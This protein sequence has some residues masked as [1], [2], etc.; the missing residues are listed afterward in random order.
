MTTVFADEYGY[1]AQDGGSALQAAID[2]PNADRIIVRDMGSPWLIDRQIQ[3]K[4][5]KEIVFEAGSVVQAKPGS[6]LAN[7][8]AMIVG[9]D[10]QN[11]QLI[12][13]G[14]GA[15]KATIKMN[16]EEY[17][18]SQ[19]GH[20]VSLLGV[21]GYEVSGLKLT[22]AGGDGL[23]IAAGSFER[24][25]PN[26][27][28]YS[29]NG[30]VDNIT[31]DNNR[32]Q[33]IS[34]DSAKNLVVQNSTF[35][36]TSGV[37]PEA[38]I[39]LEPTWDYESLENIR[40]ENVEVSGNA[41]SGIQVILGN[42]DDSSAPVS[43]DFNNISLT[44]SKARGIFV[45]GGYIAE[46]NDFGD[47]FK[48]TIDEN[49]P[50]AQVNGTINFNN[51]NISNSGAIAS[52]NAA[53]NPETYI[54]VEDISGNQADPNNL[55]INFN[56]VNI[57]D[58]VDTTVRT[59]PIFIQGLPGETK[60]QEIGNLSFNDTSITGN[61]NGDVV[62]ADLGRADAGLSNV[63]GDIAVFNAN[64]AGAGIYIDSEENAT[65]LNLNVFEGD[66]SAPPA[67]QTSTVT[68]ETI[69]PVVSTNAFVEP[70]LII[71]DSGIVTEPI[72]PVVA[73]DSEIAAEPI[74]EIDNIESG[75]TAFV[76]PVETG[77]STNAIEE[78]TGDFSSAV[79][80]IDNNVAPEN[81]ATE[82]TP[83]IEPTKISIPIQNSSF[84]D[85]LTGWNP[86]GGN[87]SV[88]ERSP[89]DRWAK[90]D[91]N[92]G[93]VSQD[94]S[95]S[96]VPGSNY[97][98]SATTQIADSQA[99]GYIGVRFISSTEELS[100]LQYA[101]VSGNGTQ[102]TQASFTAP[103]EFARAEIFAFKNNGSGA[104]FVD[105]FSLIEQ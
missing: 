16:K 92:I 72:E 7:D 79:E 31:S 78:E 15:D 49:S 18:S 88:V 33:G 25:D 68:A 89:G 74:E 93:D 102:E 90:I 103:E 84:T 10:V 98:V 63:S 60:A 64:P 80:A 59:T 42:L 4:S 95:G 61:Y 85:S 29:A 37:K 9:R 54:F 91:S 34:I 43:I 44:D 24:P 100:S 14:S 52:G 69:E 28:P 3:L 71:E 104:L 75:E 21:D 39:N 57:N 55:K 22:G 40:I 101:S 19:Y 47:E 53:N 62:V 11:V 38:G 12:G 27:L 30:L 81:P 82:T 105:D 48:G 32:R 1:N 96:I 36:N 97:Q 83:L 17:N 13:E 77:N 67:N 45:A 99:R 87:V 58:P 5:N 41:G 50:Q 56:N 86:T 35:T 20:I 46:G 65:N 94:I 2:D 51:T 70:D 73:E 6:F 66:A 76:E 23:H 8:R 26:F